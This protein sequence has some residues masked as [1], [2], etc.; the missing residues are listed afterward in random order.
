M[1]I[2]FIIILVVIVL[3]FPALLFSFWVYASL[4]SNSNVASSFIGPLYKIFNASTPATNPMNAFAASIGAMFRSLPDSLFIGSFVLSAIFQSLPLFMI[5]IA[6]IEL[7]LGRLAIGKF[8]SVL[9]SDY[10]MQKPSV[11]SPQCS[12][13]VHYNTPES[14]LS[15]IANRYKITFPS[16]TMFIMGGIASYI[17]TSVIQMKDV[18]TNLGPEWEGRLYIMLTTIILGF[19]TFIIHQRIYG[20]DTLGTLLVSAILAIFSGSILSFAHNKLFGKEAINILG[21]PYL[22]NRLETGAPL[23][24]CSDKNIGA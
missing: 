22:D 10:S 8:A 2:S 19:A 13:G 23:Y 4:T 16:D 18:L 12:P 6:F 11:S 20:C 3:F 21:L 24:V 14:I 9:S 7:S 5:F 17:A 1:D 15:V